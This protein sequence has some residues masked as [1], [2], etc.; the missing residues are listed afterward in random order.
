MFAANELLIPVSGDYLSLQGLSRMIQILKR[1]EELADHRIKLWLV[2]TR[3]QMRRK[4]TEEV[5]N[6]ILKY[7]PGRVFF[8]PVR[9]NVAL[10]ECPSFGKTIFDYRKKSPGAEDYMSLAE[11]VMSRR[12]AHV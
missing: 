3:M 10:A 6:R 11:D 5:R 7:F 9:E 4:L 12:T 2:S 8:T 1:A